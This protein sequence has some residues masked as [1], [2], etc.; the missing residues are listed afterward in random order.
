MGV[1][2]MKEKRREE[3]RGKNITKYNSD[4]IFFFVSE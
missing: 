1:E 4:D 3:R 2:R